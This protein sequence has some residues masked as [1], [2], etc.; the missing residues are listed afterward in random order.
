MSRD[1]FY[2]KAA[3]LDDDALRKALWT[4]YWRGGA[5]MR[6]RIEAQLDP[7]QEAAKRKQAQPPPDPGQVLQEV[8]DFVDLASGGAYLGRDRRVSPKE[9]SGWRMTFRRLANDAQAALRH[10]D[11]DPAASALELLVDLACETRELDLFRSQDP[12]QAAGF[13]VSDAVEL[14]WSRLRDAHGFQGF[15]QRAAPQLIRW[16]APY[17]WTRYGVGSVAEKEATL[18]TVLSQRL[19]RIPDHWETF[20][21]SYLAAL[22]GVADRDAATAKYHWRSRDELRSHRAETLADWHQ[23]LLERL[24]DAEALA[25]LTRLA[26]HPAL[27]GPEQ[28]YLEA[29]L[30]YRNGD[31]VRAQ[32]LIGRCLDTLPGHERFREAARRF[33]G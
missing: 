32:Q 21:V 23:V 28:T 13:V 14:L 24:H 3:T 1:E 27:A 5:Q 15:A 9:R 25:L 19:L 4:L 20:A 26:A 10:D 6:E 33:E 30:A 2:A 17:G 18:T 16:E 22:D 12:V 29:E 8:S 31:A 7:Q 11:I